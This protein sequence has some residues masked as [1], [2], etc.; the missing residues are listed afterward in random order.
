MF[1]GPDDG[2]S[3]L[4]TL[5]FGR[6][7]STYPL[8][9]CFLRLCTCGEHPHVVFYR[10]TVSGGRVGLL[11]AARTQVLAIPGHDARV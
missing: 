8:A 3:P 2:I 11:T 10:I 1:L 7:I 4:P 6:G 9:S 5:V